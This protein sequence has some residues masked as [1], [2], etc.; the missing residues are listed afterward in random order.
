MR[1]AIVAKWSSA[2]TAD[3]QVWVRIA[4]QHRGE[5]ASSGDSKHFKMP[6]RSKSTFV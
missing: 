4:H 6:R 1:T 2:V 5:E 3:D